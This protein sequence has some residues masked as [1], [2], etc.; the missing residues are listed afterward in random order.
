V[1]TAAQE[2][3]DIARTLCDRDNFNRPALCAIDNR[4]GTH[5]PEKYQVVGEVLA[6]MSHPWQLPEGCERAKQFVY[7]PVGRINVVG[8]DVFPD[9]I[10]IQIDIDAEDN[11]VKDSAFGVLLIFV[12]ALRAILLDRPF[13]RDPAKPTAARVLD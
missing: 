6:F 9:F 13:R 3:R 1:Q 12:E 8:G 2:G 5:R 7:P 4:V 11:S 10:E